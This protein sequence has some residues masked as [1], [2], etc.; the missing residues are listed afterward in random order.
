MGEGVPEGAPTH[1][2]PSPAPGGAAPLGLNQ[3]AGTLLGPPGGMRVPVEPTREVGVKVGPEAQGPPG[4]AGPKP[5]PS[6]ASGAEVRPHPVIAPPPHDGGREVPQHQ[7]TSATLPRVKPLAATAPEPLQR[8]AGVPLGQGVGEGGKPAPNPPRPAALGPPPPQSP[9]QGTSQYETGRLCPTQGEPSTPFPCDRDGLSLQSRGP[10]GREICSPSGGEGTGLGPSGPW[11]PTGPNL[12]TG[13]QSPCPAD[14]LTDGNQTSISWSVTYAP[15]TDQSAA[16]TPLPATSPET[17]N[18]QHMP[19]GWCPSGGS[20]PSSKL[21]GLS[22]TVSD[23]TGRCDGSIIRHPGSCSTHHPAGLPSP[24]PPTPQPHPKLLTPCKPSS[25]TSSNGGGMTQS[26]PMKT[27]PTTTM[28]KTLEVDM[29][30]LVED[31][32]MSTLDKIDRGCFAIGPAAPT[33][34]VIQDVLEPGEG[35]S[36]ARDLGH[37]GDPHPPQDLHLPL[38]NLDGKQGH[39]L[40]KKR[41]HFCGLENPIPAKKADDVGSVPF[42]GQEAP[43][44]H[45]PAKRVRVGT[46]TVEATRLR[47]KLLLLT[48]GLPSGADFFSRETSLFLPGPGLV[49]GEGAIMLQSYPQ[50]ASAGTGFHPPTLQV[51]EAITFAA[52]PIA[53]AARAGLITAGQGDPHIVGQF[54]IT[55]INPWTTG[56]APNMRSVASTLQPILR[57]NQAAQTR[58]VFYS[59]LTG[60]L[61]TNLSRYDNMYMYAKL[62]YYAFVLDVCALIGAQPD[63]QGFGANDAPLAINLA[64]N[65]YDGATLVDAMDLGHIVVFDGVDY[66]NTEAMLWW[67]LVAAGRRLDGHPPAPGV[68]PVA[69]NRSPHSFYV[70]WER[71]EVVILHHDHAPVAPPDGAPIPTADRFI[72][73]ASALATRRQEEDAFV[74]GAYMALDLIGIRGVIHNEITRFVKSDLSPSSL[75]APRVRDSNFLLRLLRLTAITSTTDISEMQA[76]Q[77]LT[78]SQRARACTLYSGVVNTAVTV[79]LA[80]VNITA[81]DVQHFLSNQNVTQ[82]LLDVLQSTFNVVGRSEMRRVCKMRQLIA[83][84]FKEWLSTSTLWGSCPNNDWIGPMGGN[85]DAAGNIFNTL[86]ADIPPRWFNPN[87]LL[88]FIG[89]IPCEF[90]YVG[91]KPSLNFT[92]ETVEVG[93]NGAVGWFSRLG[94][95]KYDEMAVAGCPY[96]LVPY[97]ALA[98][99]AIHQLLRPADPYPV[100]Q[101]MA[102]AWLG[103]A[104]PMW[105]VPAVLPDMQ[106]YGYVGNAGPWWAFAPCVFRSFSHTHNAV[107]ALA[108]Q[109]NQIPVANLREVGRLNTPAADSVGFKIGCTPTPSLRLAPLPGLFDA[110][111]APSYERSSAA[112]ASVKAPDAPAGN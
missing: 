82:T 93:P 61:E 109:P 76:L 7:G 16:G 15:L 26:T 33:T 69:A 22:G 5:E 111:A 73:F 35:I 21:E 75:L 32:V 31:I 78:A 41:P 58:E 34:E 107:I 36:P 81:A 80:G 65:N 89:D 68:D 86:P 49:V 104:K 51:G 40:C 12:Q 102:P 8:G 92:A 47:P 9:S 3:G 54:E 84:A 46:N 13:E 91:P 29:R 105:G 94:D 39:R 11:Q 66:V 108:L 95:N 57:M 52:A 77:A 99:N 19:D 110:V 55:C 2:P 87:A 96:I 53:A 103:A 72:R 79:A 106:P 10:A 43:A 64:A 45:S 101:Q 60:Q 42:R 88:D 63:L 37:G 74:R 23:N 100:S 59:R 17:S 27:S 48:E 71:I 14:C 112:P 62:I 97:G 18:S 85:V 1:P 20:K 83:V 50:L 44:P 4:S 67:W 28:M 25:M 98:V 6:C 38:K 30:A 24:P 70:E 90:G 56:G